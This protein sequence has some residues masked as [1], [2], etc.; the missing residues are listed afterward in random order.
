MPKGSVSRRKVVRNKTYWVCR[1]HDNNKKDCNS[2]RIREESIYKAFIRMYNKLADNYQKILI[3]MLSQL[4]KLQ[5][6]KAKN[7]LEISNI[8]KQIA[9]LSEQN[10]VIN[11]LQSKGI[12]DSAL[13]ISQP[14]EI[15]K[16]I[17]NLKKAKNQILQNDMNKSIKNGHRKKN[18]HMV[19]E[20]LQFV[21]SAQIGAVHKIKVTLK[22]IFII[23]LILFIAIN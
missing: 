16:K 22:E 15:N 9:E 4:E 6:I 8:N 14:D 19:D 18:P 1:Q 12:L 5:D 3:P 10:Q 17:A 7:N 11:G 21:L 2:C 13:F 23:N 20:L